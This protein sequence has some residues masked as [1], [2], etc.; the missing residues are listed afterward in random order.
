LKLLTKVL[1][2]RQLHSERFIEDVFAGVI[3]FAAV[4]FISHLAAAYAQG[5]LP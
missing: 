1:R 3:I 2:Q 4:Y 5:R